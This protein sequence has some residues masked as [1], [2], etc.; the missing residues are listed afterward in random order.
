MYGMSRVYP[1][2]SALRKKIIDLFCPARLRNNPF[3]TARKSHLA[4]ILLVVRFPTLD[5][6]HHNDFSTLDTYNFPLTRDRAELLG[7]DVG[8]TAV[9]MGRM[10]AQMHMKANGTSRSFSARTSQTIVHDTAS[11]ESG[12]LTSTK[13]PHSIAPKGRFLVSLMPFSPTKL[14]TPTRVPVTSCINCFRRRTLQS[15][16]RLTVWR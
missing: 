3:I 6:S 4:R 7:V 8:S 10:L 5:E 13:W 2:P 12:S 14:T 11:R 16:K 1:L 15:A 9:K